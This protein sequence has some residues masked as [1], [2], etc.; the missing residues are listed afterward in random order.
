MEPTGERRGGDAI[1]AGGTETAAAGVAGNVLARVLV[2]GTRFLTSP[3]TNRAL[4]AAGRGILS[5]VGNASSLFA[6]GLTPK[7]SVS[8][9]RTWS[10]KQFLL[11]EYAGTAA[12]VGG[13]AGTV[14]LALFLAS[15]PLL[16]DGLYRN[17]GFLFLLLSF[18]AV[19]ILIVRD[20]LHSIFQMLGRMSEYNRVIRWEAAA[21]F[22][23]TVGL[24]LA[25]RFTVLTALLASIAVALFS[26]G[27]TVRWLVR[28]VPPPW[29]VSRPLLSESLRD[30]LK[31]HPAGIATFLFLKVDILI[32]NCFLPSAEVGRYFVAVLIAEV[33]FLIPYGTQAVLFSRV[34]REKTPEAAT[35]IAVRAGRHSFYLTLAGAAAFALAGEWIVLL[36]GGREFL[37]ALRPLRI[38]LP[39]IV[40]QCLTMTLSPLW[41]RKGI[42]GTMSLVAVVVAALNIGL[43]LV[44]IP[45]MGI[46]GAAWATTAS[47]GV[48]AGIWLTILYRHAPDGP[49]A[50]FRLEREDIRY[51]R[52]L[53]HEFREKTW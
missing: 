27:C 9:Y 45:G 38:L 41:A 14:I 16:R 18:S 19:P 46:A 50:M 28:H 6:V 5:V 49:R 1:P 8:Y 40:F 47:Y 13:A 29:K 17:T 43:N 26:L 12:A 23:L 10:G 30:A 35:G 48:N 24:L 42:Y 31:I 20:Y 32:L 44:L 36:V 11:G 51:Y 53:W 25:G 3:F 33:L 21:G 34:S 15:Y 37:P 39:G 2:L 22:L 52:D 4:G 7:I